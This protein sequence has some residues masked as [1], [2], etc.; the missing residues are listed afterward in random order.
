MGF[1]DFDVLL[2]VEEGELELGEFLL[3]YRDTCTTNENLR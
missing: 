2:K 1:G 3:G